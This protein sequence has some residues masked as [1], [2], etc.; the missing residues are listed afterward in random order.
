MVHPDNPPIGADDDS[1]NRIV[2][3]LRTFQ[4][5]MVERA[6]SEKTRADAAEEQLRGLTAESDSTLLKATSEAE[7]IRQ[8]AHQEAD[9]ILATAR[10]QAASEQEHVLG[11]EKTF[12]ESVRSYLT[13]IE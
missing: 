3:E 7:E 10:T 11:R 6:K 8:A 12:V 4:Q 5:Q 1:L 2:D 9:E 13:D